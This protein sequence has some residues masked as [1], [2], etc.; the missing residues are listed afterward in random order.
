MKMP[1]TQDE[2][3]I[4]PKLRVFVNGM[5]AGV[6]MFSIKVS[7]LVRSRDSMTPVSEDVQKFKKPFLSYASEDRVAV[8][9]AAQLLNALKMEYFQ[10][11]LS[12]SPGDRWE[13]RL[14]SEIQDCDLFL[15]F[16]SRHARDSKWVIMEAEY[17]LKCSRD[18]SA[19]RRL[20][21]VPILLEG[22]PAPLPPESLAEVHFNDPLRH[23]IFA[24][25][26]IRRQGS[27][28][29]S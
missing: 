15:L 2:T 24:E 8:L 11:I 7:P 13:R 18:P 1:W 16:W 26:A 14:Y 12:L 19:N 28:G 10:D 29:G 3:I 5:P 25:E 27:P 22:P 9:K 4:R 17:A 6:V 21:I 23:V 20:E